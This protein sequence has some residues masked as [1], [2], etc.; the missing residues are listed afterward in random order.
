MQMY[1][2]DMLRGRVDWLKQGGVR[3]WQAS[4][5]ATLKQRACRVARNRSVCRLS[6]LYTRSTLNYVAVALTGTIRR[7]L[8]T[9]IYIGTLQIFLLTY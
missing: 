1:K 2:I 8:V 3:G 9:F 6:R 4:G 7:R 5:Q